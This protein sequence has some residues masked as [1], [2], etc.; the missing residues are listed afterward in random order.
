LKAIKTAFALQMRHSGNSWNRQYRNHGIS[1]ERRLAYTMDPILNG[2]P[3]E[4]RSRDGSALGLSKP[5]VTEKT[6]VR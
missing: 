3:D 2:N 6:S 5:F 1:P 4:E